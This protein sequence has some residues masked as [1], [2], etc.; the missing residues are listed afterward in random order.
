MIHQ[1]DYNQKIIKNKGE[2]KMSLEKKTT[3]KF[4]TNNIVLNKISKYVF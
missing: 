2:R 4:A 1:K 3:S